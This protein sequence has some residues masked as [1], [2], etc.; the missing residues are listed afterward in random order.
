M[1]NFR[2]S[3]GLLDKMI[4]M[5]FIN[6]KDDNG[7]MIE[8]GGHT[9]DEGGSNTYFFEKYLDYKTFLI[10][11][12]KKSFEELQK[13]RPNSVN[14]NKAV[15]YKKEMIKLFGDNEIANTIGNGDEF[16]LV[17]SEPIRDMLEKYNLKYVDLFV[18]DTEG[19]E[20]TVLETFD[21]NIEVG[22]I[23][24]ELLSETP[25]GN[26]LTHLEKDKKVIDFLISKGFTYQFSDYGMTNQIW[27]NEKYSRKDKIFEGIP[28]KDDDLLKKDH[29]KKNR[30][31][32]YKLSNIFN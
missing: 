20:L 21:W 18:I 13:N 25:S 4:Y 26:Y 5:N 15:S 19:S 27:I 11:P 12:S 8:I 32:Q 7:I 2:F 22:V 14:I 29:Y 16:S 10:E 28:N 9:G 6:K 30:I 23:L 1:T 31:Y 24:V 17:K 3:R